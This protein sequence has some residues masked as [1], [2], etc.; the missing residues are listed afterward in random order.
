MAQAGRKYGSY[1]PRVVLHSFCVELL[2]INH[3]STLNSEVS[4]KVKFSASI[5]LN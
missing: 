2:L 5:G 4:V 3:I 1:E